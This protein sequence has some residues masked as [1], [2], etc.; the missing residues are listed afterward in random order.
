[1]LR[2]GTARAPGAPDVLAF[3][4][5]SGGPAGQSFAMNQTLMREAIG[6]ALENLANTSGGPFGAVIVRDGEIVGRGRNEVVPRRDPTA[7]AE[8]TAIREACQEI[9]SHRLDG[10]Q[11]Y[12]SCEPCPMCWSAIHWARLDR[13]WYGATRAD[14]ARAGFDDELLYEELRRGLG[15]RRLPAVQLLPDEALAAFIAWER[16][17]DKIAY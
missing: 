12:S 9:G 6:L 1:M 4:A 8:V 7:H 15:E 17:V 2:A 16:K 13:V 11:I 5:S 10:C 14:A 3:Q